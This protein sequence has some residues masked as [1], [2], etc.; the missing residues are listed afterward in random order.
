MSTRSALMTE[1]FHKCGYSSVST[2]LDQRE[3]P[4]Q[5]KRHEIWVHPQTRNRPGTKFIRFS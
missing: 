1:S 2:F 3:R 4:P 5:V